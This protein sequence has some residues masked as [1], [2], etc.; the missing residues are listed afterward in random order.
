M[1]FSLH[2][3]RERFAMG[4]ELIADPDTAGD[5][6]LRASWGRLQIW[7]G[8]R[9][10]TA[11]TSAD[12][13]HE[14]AE[15]PLL[16]VIDWLIGA[17]D[18]LLHEERFPW[19]VQ[20]IS[21]AEWHIES[22]S[23]LDSED[24]HLDERL[25]ERH[26]WWQRHGLGASLP[27]YRIPDVHFRRYAEEIEI[28]W[29]DRE[30]RT[31][32][33]G[34]TLI[35]AAGVAWFPVA[36]T[37]AVLESWCRSALDVL[38]TLPETAPRAAE[39]RARLDDLRSSAR[40]EKRLLWAAGEAI[41][42]AARRIRSL[43]GLEDDGLADT[44]RSL[45]GVRGEP[46]AAYYAVLPAPTLLFRSASPRISD[47][48][49]HALLDLCAKAPP[50]METAGA[51]IRAPQPCPPSRR[52]S[53][54]QGCEL[55]LALRER[56]A[57]PADA[58]LTGD[59][60]IE[61]ILERLHV[62]FEELTLGDE[63]VDGAALVR[64]GGRPVVAVNRSGRFARTPWGRRMTLAHELCHV[65][66]DGDASGLVGVVSGEWAP[67]LPERRANAFAAML[68]APEAALQALL[69]RRPDRWTAADL[70]RAMQV[71]GVG[72]T[73]LTRQLRNLKWISEA[74]RE[75]WVDALATHDS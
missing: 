39:L 3:T 44:V 53:T 26:A 41:V 34:V 49:L 52:A 55:A 1:T 10:L 27:D 14:Q 50:S 61:R 7:V 6:V 35:E 48:D 54:Q 64:S 31:V 22:I 29:D 4:F 5:A 47:T 32:P 11:A 43:V 13:R 73:T 18:P 75:A 30:W 40:Q 15:C 68:L 25:D 71:L 62:R 19:P 37:A 70:R 16:P 63:G 51:G 28:S 9:N 46:A 12:A 65:L 69:D 58:P 67:Y 59:L 17:W 20:V 74:E 2:G 24:A 38:A 8:G 56:L 36:E 42:R 33:E 66:H 72:A 60:D 57:I 23:E 45:L 21:S